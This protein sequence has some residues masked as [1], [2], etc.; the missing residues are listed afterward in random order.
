MGSYVRDRH[1]SSPRETIIF[2]H[3]N[4]SCRLV[5]YSFGYEGKTTLKCFCLITI[6]FPLILVAAGSHRENLSHLGIINGKMFTLLLTTSEMNMELRRSIFGEEVWVLLQ[7]FFI[8][9]NM[10]ESKELFQ[11]IHT[12]IFKHSSIN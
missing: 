8:Q 12:L 4:G 10:G 9:P 1:A 5:M 7:L 6:L 2:L 3:A 11:I